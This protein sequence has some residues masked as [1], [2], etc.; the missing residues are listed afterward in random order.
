[1]GTQSFDFVNS[2]L[3][4]LWCNNYRPK[5]TIIFVKPLLNEPVIIRFN[6]C[7]SIMDIGM[8]REFDLRK[9]TSEN[10]IVNFEISEKLFLQQI[11][12]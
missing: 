5:K 1:M 4:T 8:N 11:I 3:R 7:L 10:S 6:S 9:W 12:I 2:V